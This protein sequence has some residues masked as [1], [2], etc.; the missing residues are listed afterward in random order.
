MDTHHA[1]IPSGSDFLVQVT[2]EKG[3]MATHR[4]FSEL[5]A[6]ARVGKQKRLELAELNRANPSPKI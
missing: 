6:I 2:Y 1:V 4:F 5:D 3:A